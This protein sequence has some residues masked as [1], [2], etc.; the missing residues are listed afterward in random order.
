M[1]GSF[2]TKPLCH[3]LQPLGGAWSGA[4]G[5]KNVYVVFAT[6][7]VHLNTVCRTLPPG[8][9]LDTLPPTHWTAATTQFNSTADCELSHAFSHDFVQLF[10]AVT[11]RTTCICLCNETCQRRSSCQRIAERLSRS[12]RG[13][14]SRSYWRRNTRG[15]W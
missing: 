2:S 4:V 1:A 14:R 7:A 10:V 11:R 6:L 12:D 3:E 5:C 8:R 13:Q 9:P 15:R